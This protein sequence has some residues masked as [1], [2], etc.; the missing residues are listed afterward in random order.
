M[1]PKKCLMVALYAKFIHIEGFFRS[2]KIQIEPTDKMFPY[3]EYIAYEFLKKPKVN[4]QFFT[5]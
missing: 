3:L 2:L 5:D 1:Y 4:R